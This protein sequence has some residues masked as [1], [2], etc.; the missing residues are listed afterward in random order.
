MGKRKTVAAGEERTGS[1]KGEVADESWLTDLQEEEL[2]TYYARCL[3]D[4]SIDTPAVSQF[5]FTNDGAEVL[6]ENG[7]KVPICKFSYA[8]LK[9]AYICNI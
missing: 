3:R 5:R 8:L 4:Y 9:S 1:S 7:V 6:F 2:Y